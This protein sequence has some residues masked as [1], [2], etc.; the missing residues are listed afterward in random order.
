MK[1]FVG[2]RIS[3]LKGKFKSQK[4]TIVLNQPDV[5]DTQEKLHADFALI[6]TDKAAHKVTVVYK[7]Y[8]LETQ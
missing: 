3:G 5:K 8:Y 6:P 2:D 7:K 1:E 4:F